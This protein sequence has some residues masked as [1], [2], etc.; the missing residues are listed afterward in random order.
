MAACIVQ[1]GTHVMKK[2]YFLTLL[3]LLSATAAF[4]A[5]API[6][7]ASIDK[8]SVLQIRQ[9][10]SPPVIIEKTEYYEIRGGSERELRNQMLQHGVTWEDGKRYDS[11]TSWY[12]TWDYGTGHTGQTCS[13]DD[14][15]ITLEIK[16]RLPKW[17]RTDEASQSLVDKWEGYV[18]N[19]TLHENGHREMALD[20]AAHFAGAVARLPHAL[21]CADRDQRVRTLSHELMAQLNAAQQD[22]DVA[23][24]HGASQGAL[25]P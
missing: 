24:D 14:F 8:E 19:L 20:A 10:Y 13:A 7:I 18:K 15:S 11:L 21:N 12:W 16:L 1:Q 25:F 4:A 9:P 2:H 5:E 6:E 23:T 22:Y 17:V 3:F